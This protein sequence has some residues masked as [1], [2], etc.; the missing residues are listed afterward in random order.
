M[1]PYPHQADSISEIMNHFNT[2]NR[3]LYCLPTGG[4]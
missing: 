4:G 2:E 1:T 3:L